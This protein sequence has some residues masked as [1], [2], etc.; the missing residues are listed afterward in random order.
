VR[1]KLLYSPRALCER[2]ALE[3]I[4]RK[5]LAKIRKTAAKCLSISHI[6]SLELLELSSSLQ[7]NI[8]YDVGANV[9]TWSI[10]AK[11]IIPDAQIHAF[12]PL[13]THQAGFIQNTRH[14]ENVT[15]HRVALGSENAQSLIHIT[16]LSDASSM[17]QLAPAGERQFG[18]SEIGKHPL[19]MRQLDDY[20]VENDLPLPDLLKL[21]VQGYELEVLKGGAQCA[22]VAKAMIVEVS[23]TEY[24]ENQCLFQ[25]IVGQLHIYGFTVRAF[26]VNTPLGQPLTQADVLFTRDGV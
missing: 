26:A 13:A 7:I 1:A 2:L 5:R 20:R 8:I 16:N 22:K 21:D 10:L 11:A 3:S 12:E 6:D 19:L 23:F 17:L 9:G 14:L 18:I 25:E 4:K 15:L 24:Y